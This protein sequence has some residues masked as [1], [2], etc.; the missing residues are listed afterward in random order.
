MCIPTL[1]LQKRVSA[2]FASARSVIGA[3]TLSLLNR[4]LTNCSA[5]TDSGLSSVLL[6]AS[7]FM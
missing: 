3:A 2:K 7:S 4:P 6:L 5:S 1:P